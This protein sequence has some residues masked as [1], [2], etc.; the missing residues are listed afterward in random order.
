MSNIS[1]LVPH[2]HILVCLLT[3]GPVAP[4]QPFQANRL[5]EPN[6][7]PGRDLGQHQGG[8]NPL[9]EVSTCAGQEHRQRGTV[10]SEC[11][12]ISVFV[13]FLTPFMTLMIQLP[14][15]YTLLNITRRSKTNGPSKTVRVLCACVHVLLQ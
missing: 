2:L 10:L 15:R 3:G 13:L 9:L 6:V 7:H 14:S 11:E 8:D 5:T 4:V 12:G 1:R